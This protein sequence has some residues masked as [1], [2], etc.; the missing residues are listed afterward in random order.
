MF[1][2]R[3]ELEPGCSSVQSTVQALTVLYPVPEKGPK[4][5]GKGRGESHSFKE[6]DQSHV[7]HRE[8]DLTRA[9]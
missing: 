7:I 4:K 3:L 8:M 1:E 9:M 2:L 5:K 6:E